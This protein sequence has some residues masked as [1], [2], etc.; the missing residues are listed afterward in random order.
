MEHT[1]I[2]SSRNFWSFQHLKGLVSAQK[3]EIVESYF[4]RL[5][6]SQDVLFVTLQEDNPVED[7]LEEDFSISFS[8]SLEEH[9]FS[10]EIIDVS[11]GQPLATAS[12][13]RKMSV[14]P[15]EK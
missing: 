13:L 2:R 8:L 11:P 7:E 12:N 4:L 3:L 14:T 1:K 10:Y 9:S 15:S 6:F 5:D